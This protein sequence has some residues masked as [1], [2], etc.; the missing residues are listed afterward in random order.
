[1]LLWA[2]WRAIASA[3]QVLL[4]GDDAKIPPPRLLK[5]VPVS[6]DE[7]PVMPN[8][9]Q[10]LIIRPAIPGLTTSLSGLP[11]LFGS[12]L[13]A[14]S[15]HELGHGLAAAAEQIPLLSTGFRL[16][17]LVFPTF[18]VEVASDFDVS[19]LTDLRISSAGVWHNVL[20]ASMAWTWSDAG[21]GLT[22]WMG[23]ALG[24]WD[25]LDEG[26]SPL[27]PHL[28][29]GMLIDHIDDLELDA[30]TA[31]SA[32]PARLWHDHLSSSNPLDRYQNLGWC[33][34]AD[35][36]ST[37][38]G[39]ECCNKPNLDG[40]S[41]SGGPATAERLLCFEALTEPPNQPRS[42]ACLD[43]LPLLPPTSPSDIPPRCFD[44]Q[45]CRS[46]QGGSKTICGRISEDEH[47]VRLGVR[48]T[49]SAEVGGGGGEDSRTVLWQG[50]RQRLLHDGLSSSHGYQPKT[51][52]LHIHT[53]TQPHAGSQHYVLL[54]ITSQSTM[55][56]SA[57]TTPL[58]LEELIASHRK[59]LQALYTALSP[60][61]QPLID[62]H[63][64]S[65]HSTLSQAV[66]SQRTTAEAEVADA[67]ARLSAGWRRVHDWQT[68]LGEPLRQEK[69]RG[70][71]PLLSLVEEV[72]QIKEGMKGRMEERGKRILQLQA[73]LRELSEVVGKDWLQVELE[74]A[75]AEG[76][77]EDLNL[78]L[79]R[80]GAL[81][82]E[83][84]RCEA[85]ISHRKEL[86][87][88]HASEV[89]ALRC[90]LGIH[91]AEEGNPGGDPLDEDIL[92]H[93]GVG[94]AR[95]PKR[96]MLPTAENVQRVEAKRKWLEDEKDSRNMLIQTTYDKLYPLWT[97]LGVTEEEMEDFV[98]RHMGSTQ[99]V[100]NAYQD[101]L[102][103][104]L[105][106]KRSNMSTFIQRER[107]AMTALWDRLYVSYP[108]RLAQF[109][110]YSISVEPTKVWNAAHGYDEEVVNDNVS[111]ELLVAHER[112]RERL[113]KEVEEAAPVLER[114]AKY[115]AVVEK[116]KELEAAAADPSRLMD[117]SRGAAKRL[118]QEA[119]DRKQVDR[120]KPR[121]EAELRALIPQWEAENGR[122]FLVN[123]VSFIDGLDEQI[124]AEELEKENKKRAKMGM[125]ASAARPLKPQ[126][127]GAAAPAPLKRQMTGASA[128]STSSSTSTGPPAAKRLAAGSVAPTPAA[129]RIARP[130]SVLGDAN[131]LHYTPSATPAPLK[132]QMTGRAR[133][134]TLSASVAQTPLSASQSSNGSMASS[135]GLGMRIP[136][137]W[138]ASAAGTGSPAMSPT[139]GTAGVGVGGARGM[140]LP[141]PTGGHF[142]PMGR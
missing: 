108:Q 3:A 93:L 102:N 132:P 34:D 22:N 90:E 89:F 73:K 9:T 12:L 94:E 98:N 53:G 119:K 57:S 16:F 100:V 105:T 66:A 120:E 111:E 45:S 99:D 114:L 79:D 124:R 101:E 8:P 51:P 47:V 81:E 2:A 44:D 68:A 29:T 75:A 138:G 35:L 128:R 37:S 55:A 24:I 142:R 32:D 1:M 72:D 117:K 82:R 62:T 14:Q 140:L 56:D 95:Q 6:L 112:E 116:M 52:L 135:V 26:H 41:P 97:M 83:L 92:W 67:E 125:S 109:P 7:S 115:F 33:L 103:R 133:S 127:T 107:E 91:Q 80:M 11:V 19:P 86:L 77:W 69:K 78:K 118:A 122:P 88:S 74:A 43:P 87:N 27:A 28:A 13:V 40:M 18:H 59:I 136:A 21:A 63:L 96:E 20:L 110:A 64:T 85:E 31:R 42:Q 25:T 5:R 123:G 4:P 60:S 137:G 46:L 39:A 17:L 113:E 30:A 131:G 71:G 104:M 134:G 38:D 121:L 49:S 65:L 129:A 76:K 130:K 126:H 84:L 106:L 70:D 141:Q 48:N 139:L 23:R 10:G 58:S 36:F 15:F 50:S 61:P 54:L